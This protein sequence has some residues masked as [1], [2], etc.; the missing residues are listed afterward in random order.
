MVFQKFK[1]AHAETIRD[2]VAF[3]LEI[4]GVEKK[5]SACSG[6]KNCW[7]SSAE[8]KAGPI[9]YSFPA[10]SS[11]AI[12]L[13]EHGKPS[14]P[15]ICDEPTSALDSLTTT[16]ILKLLKDINHKQ[17]VTIIIITPR[18]RRGR[19]DRQQCRHHRRIQDHRAQGLVKDVINN[20]Q[21]EITK[22]C[23]KGVSLGE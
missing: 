4:A 17:G 14:V 1:P 8:F 9:R 3:P 21:Q 5:T 22:N 13:Q 11:S 20:P 12:P 16:S 23:W 15:A 18:D 7:R 6:W 19:K 2:N 10:D